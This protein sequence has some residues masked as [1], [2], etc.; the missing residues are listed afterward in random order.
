[1]IIGYTTG[2]FDLFHVGHLNILER[3]KEYCDELIVGVCTDEYALSTKGKLPIIP[4]ED[5]ARIISSLKCVDRVVPMNETDKLMAWNNLH[6][7]V[8][9]S[10]DDWKGTERYQKTE[11][12]FKPLGVDII[13]FPYTRGVSTTQI[14]KKITSV[15]N[16]DVNP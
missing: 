11:M 13:Y 15:Y 5:R 3:C 12:Q 9:F 10:G 14:L 4:Y 6:F 8:L 2:V 1:M 7:N 16:P